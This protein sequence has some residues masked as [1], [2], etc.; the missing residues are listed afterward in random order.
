MPPELTKRGGG[1]GV[2]ILI[3]SGGREHAVSAFG[4]T[5]AGAWLVVSKVR[6]VPP[7]PT[8]FFCILRLFFHGCEVEIVGNG[9]AKWREGDHHSIEKFGA[10]AFGG[11]HDGGCTDV[12]FTREEIRWGGQ[13]GR[14]HGQTVCF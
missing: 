12:F 10:R 5:A 7:L 9:R 13:K 1:G 8:P 14:G 6:L 3:G 11:V 2:I 4:L